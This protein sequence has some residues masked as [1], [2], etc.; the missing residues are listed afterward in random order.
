V[1][2]MITKPITG[3]VRLESETV[4]VIKAISESILMEGGAPR[5]L[6]ERINHQTVIAGKR[7]IMPF[8]TIKFRLWAVSYIVLAKAKRP[9]EASPWAV[10]NSRAPVH[11]H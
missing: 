9:E 1:V 3:I 5:F 2:S 8:N 6:A 11:P 7:F 10:I 4:A